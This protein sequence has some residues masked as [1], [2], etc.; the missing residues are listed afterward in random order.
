[1][2]P[3]PGPVANYVVESFRA[4]LPPVEL[5]RPGAAGCDAFLRKPF[6]LEALAATVRPDLGG[7]AGGLPPATPHAG[8]LVP[9]SIS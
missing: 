5:E 3:G 7:L 2:T 4:V 6:G 1:M 8:G 9:L